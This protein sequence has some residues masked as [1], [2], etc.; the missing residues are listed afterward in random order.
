M[1]GSVGNME[2]DFAEGPQYI[3][4]GEGGCAANSEFLLDDYL[5]REC[6]LYMN[7]GG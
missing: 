3:F 1:A 5:T 4:E 2:Y 6:D 7:I